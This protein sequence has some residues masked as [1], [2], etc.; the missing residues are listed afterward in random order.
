MFSPKG[1]ELLYGFVIGYSLA[2]PSYEFT[3]DLR[4]LGMVLIA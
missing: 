3:S 2:F 4:E 1:D